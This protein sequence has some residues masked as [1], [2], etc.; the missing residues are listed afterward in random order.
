MLGVLIVSTFFYYLHSFLIH[1]VIHSLQKEPCRQVEVT[2]DKL[3]QL[4][5]YLESDT[6][7]QNLGLSST[8]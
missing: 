2:G 6:P 3:G 4:Q 5:D 1:K 8:F 7:I